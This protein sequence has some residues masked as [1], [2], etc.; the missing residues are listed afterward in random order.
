[1]LRELI[2]RWLKALF[3]FENPNNLV[4]PDQGN[5]QEIPVF[6]RLLH[7]AVEENQPEKIEDLLRQGA[8]PNMTDSLGR[9][10]LYLA[11][12]AGSL[13][14]AG[15]LLENGA[16]PD[17][18]DAALRQ[19]PLHLAVE[20]SWM[21]VE[22][23]LRYNAGT[24]FADVEGETP[25]FRA[26]RYNKMPALEPLLLAGAALDLRNKGG[27][28]PRGLAVSLYRDD[29]AARLYWAETIR[30]RW[31]EFSIGSLISSA[32]RRYSASAS[33]AA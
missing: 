14:I 15:L 16:D 6:I 10:P 22:L 3:S 4:F 8:D 9:T 21:M 1:M 32:A 13:Q 11:V 23:L 25:V 30:C 17:I 24:D 28:T 19:T 20:N 12:C 7:Q 29:M 31:S 27:Q 26:V 5:G 18:A 2:V 33:A